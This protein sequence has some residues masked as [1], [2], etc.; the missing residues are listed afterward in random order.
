[1]MSNPETMLLQITR[2]RSLMFD[3]AA[4]LSEATIETLSN[5][6]YLLTFGSV[7]SSSRESVILT[8]CFL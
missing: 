6:A 5:S 3:A 8:E 4:D 2:K 1:M 7:P